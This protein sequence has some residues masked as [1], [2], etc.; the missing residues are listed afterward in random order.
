M[1]LDSDCARHLTGSPN[2][3]TSNISEA[4]TPLHLPD[5]STVK[6]TK[7][8]TVTMKSEILG[9]TNIVDIANVELVPRLKKNL[10]SCVRLEQKGIRLVYEGKKRYLA[11]ASAKM[12]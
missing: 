8:G 6:S 10:L 1:I 7:R 2:L 12:A 11:N 3:F 4:Q 9:Q 5:G